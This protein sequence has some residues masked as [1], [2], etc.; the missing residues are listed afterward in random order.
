MENADWSVIKNMPK[1]GCADEFKEAVKRLLEIV[2]KLDITKS[3][4]GLDIGETVQISRIPSIDAIVEGQIERLGWL[5]SVDHLLKRMQ[6][7]IVRK[8]NLL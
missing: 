1:D 3:L 7:A 8:P 6:K 4:I 2:N 5:D